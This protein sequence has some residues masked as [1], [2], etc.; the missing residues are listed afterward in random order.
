MKAVIM[1]GGE[2]SRLRPLTSNTP[3]PMLPIVN[4]PMMEHIVELCAKHGITDIVVTVQFLASVIRNYFG[5]G[6]VLGVEMKYATEEVPLGTAGSVGNARDLLDDTFVVISGD[7]VTDI[8]ISK[9]VEAHKKHGALATIVLHRAENPL[10]FGIVITRDDGTIERFLEKPTW[11]QVFSDTVNT[12]IYILEPEIFDYIPEGANIDFSA[13]VFPKLLEEGKPIY[14]HIAEGYWEDVGNIEAYMRAQRDVLDG[15]VDIRVPGFQVSEG[16]WIGENAEV[17][18]GATIEGHAVIGDNCR[19]DAGAQLRE[20]CVIGDN[21]VVKAESELQRAIVFDNAYIGANAQ[22]SGALIGKATDLRQGVRVDSDAIIGDNCSIGAGAVISPAVKIYPGKTVEAG[23][24]V[25]SSI[26]WESRASSQLFGRQG[27]RGL[28]N[29]E[30]TPQLA[31]RLA[32]AYG[33]TLKPNSIVTFSRDASR[34]CRA[35]K[36]AFMAGLNATGVHADDLEIAT[37]PLTRFYASTNSGGVTIRTVDESPSDVEIRFFGSDGRDISEGRQRKIERTYAREDF[38]RELPDEMGDVFYPPRVNQFYVNGLIESVD[39]EA[40]RKFAPKVVIDFSFGT[41]STII[42]QILERVGADVL[43][44]NPFTAERSERIPLGSGPGRLGDLVRTS[45]SDL[46]IRFDAGAERADIVDDRG[47]LL[48]PIQTMLLYVTLISRTKTASKIVVPVSAPSVVDTIATEGGCKIEWSPTSAYAMMDAADQ[49]DVAIAVS[50][51]GVVLPVFQAGFDAIAQFALTLELLSQ[52]KRRLSEIVDE[53]PE[54]YVVSAT[55][56][57][58]WEKKGTVMRTLVEESDPAQQVLIDGVK[59]LLGDDTW[60]LVLPDPELPICRIW[61][62][63]KTE[64]DAHDILSRYQAKVERIV[65][66]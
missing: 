57:A 40:I 44:L 12:G 31:V 42:P 63:G 33:S 48:T 37:V 22:V 47:R 62:E 45:G 1:A 4:V 50:E 30:I 43:A 49:K 59:I 3:K 9:A 25:N 10:E 60:A 65:G 55:V 13:E 36:R 14:G 15:R 8:D 46:G 38:R 54:V 52:D 32:M 16:V 34:I 39:I 56:P 61:A 64:R 18:P 35:L 23:A 19:I 26:V 53:L 6:S 27:V 28:A 21:V 5:D 51:I 20:Y 24:L 41:A 17:D 7:A 2:G 66:S 11:G 58:P 29:I